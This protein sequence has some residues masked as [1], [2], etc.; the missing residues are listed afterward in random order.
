VLETLVLEGDEDLALCPEKRYA[1]MN[2]VYFLPTVRCLT[3][4]LQRTGFA[5]VRCI[6]V[7]PTTSAE[8]RKTEWI[9]T[10]SLS[11][12]LDPADPKRTIEGYP[13]PLRA[14]LV[15]EAR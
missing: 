12:F 8:Q 7:T 2:N 3:N 9:Q 11:D 1:K 13:A 6:D 15:A 10:E 14:T 4:W 5:N